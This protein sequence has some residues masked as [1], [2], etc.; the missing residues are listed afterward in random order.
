MYR[1]HNFWIFSDEVYRGF[2]SVHLDNE[3][4]TKGNESILY[5]FV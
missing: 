3:R 2:E 4:Q 5:M 1:E